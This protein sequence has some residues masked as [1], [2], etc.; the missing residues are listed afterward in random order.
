MTHGSERS[1]RGATQD[2]VVRPRRILV[3]LP[4]WVG[5]VV[6]ATPALEVL[7]A[8]WPDAE[9]VVEGKPFLEGLLAGHPAVDGFLPDSGRGWTAT[10]AR[11]KRLRAGRFDL[12]VLLPDSPRSAFG[13]FL[14]RIPNR[15][16]YSRDPIRRACLTLALKP[17]TENGKRVPI[18][19]PDRY[20]ALP[21]ALGCTAE[22]PPVSLPVDP[23]AVARVREMLR[24][25]GVPD[26]A[27]LVV[28]APGANFGS[29]KLYPPASFAAACDMLV[30]EEGLTVVLAPAPGE[31]DLALD[32]A[33]Q[34]QR[35]AVVLDDPP[36]SLA[37]LSALISIATLVL[38][39][40][41][42]P[43]HMAVA[44]GVPVVVTMGPTDPRHTGYQLERQRVLREDVECAPCHKKECP[45]DHRCMTRLHPSRVVEAARELL[46]RPAAPAARTQ[47]PVA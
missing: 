47:E 36:T 25:E 4:N 37:E 27:R 43:R 15:V 17:S 40:D 12:A 9:L 24:G 19:M 5:D 28:G 8:E 11:A 18:P 10:R 1:P 6:M 35:P 32:V 33:A 21:R 41:T 13:P 7:K 2:P 31:V 29:S 26:D 44:L 20:L 3:R 39:N 22:A 45:I 34:M 46:A 38:S 23:A 14:A 30:D 16:G 42:G